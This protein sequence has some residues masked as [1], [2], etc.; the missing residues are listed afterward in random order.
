MNAVIRELNTLAEIE[1][2]FPMLGHAEY[3]ALD[4]QNPSHRGWL[5]QKIDRLLYCGARYFAIQTGSNPCCGIACV[6][7]DE[8]PIELGGHWQSAE[9]MQMAVADGLRKQGYGSRLLQ[10]VCAELKTHRVYSLNLHTY[11]AD[12]DVIAFYGKNGFMPCGLVPDHYGPELEGK[13]YLRK[14]L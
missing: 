3:S 14:V 4:L 2:F 5:R 6:L 13:L 10:H 12:F 11:P 1:P 8:R 7:I 9:L